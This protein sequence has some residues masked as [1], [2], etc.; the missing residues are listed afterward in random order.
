MRLA[1]HIGEF[2]TFEQFVNLKQDKKTLDIYCDNIQGRHEKKYERSV[3]YLEHCRRHKSL[4]K[5][6]SDLSK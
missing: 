3:N 5:E 6:C 2:Q 4:D 1:Q